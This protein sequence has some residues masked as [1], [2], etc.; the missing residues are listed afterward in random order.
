MR[1]LLGCMQLD[2]SK[3]KV[4]ENALEQENKLRDKIKKGEL[5]SEYKK[6]DSEGRTYTIKNTIFDNEGKKLLIRKSFEYINGSKS[7]EKRKKAVIIKL[8]R[9]GI[10]T[11]E[12]ARNILKNSINN[13]QVEKEAKDNLLKIEG[14]RKF[15]QEMQ[16]KDLIDTPITIEETGN[17]VEIPEDDEISD[18]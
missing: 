2:T 4:V 11:Y 3:V 9:E 7:V 1:E 17:I 14:R 12:E 10:Y 5:P 13:K 8:Y 16:E 6:T 18:R 15:M